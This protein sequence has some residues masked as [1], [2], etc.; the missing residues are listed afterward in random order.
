MSGPF[1]DAQAISLFFRVIAFCALTSYNTPLEC[2][3]VSFSKAQQNFVQC[4]FVNETYTHKSRTD[5]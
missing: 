1:V 3:V 2:D 4:E 5:S